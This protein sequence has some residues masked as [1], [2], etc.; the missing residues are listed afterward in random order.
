MKPRNGLKAAIITCTVT[1][2][3]S[4]IAFACTFGA[5]RQQVADL[6]HDI[7]S[8]VEATQEARKQN[9]ALC[10]RVAALE[11]EIRAMQRD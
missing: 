9:V 8:V 10:E 3:M 5:L 11:V 2:V 1:I 4:V 7:E 6:C